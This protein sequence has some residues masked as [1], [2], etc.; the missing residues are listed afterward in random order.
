MQINDLNKV[1]NSRMFEI[2]DR[3][4]DIAKECYKKNYEAIEFSEVEHIV[5][6]GMGGSG[7]ISNFFS[8]ILSKTKIHVSIVN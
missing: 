5:F 4:P 8:S 3:W 7:T 1:D 2:Y 6:V